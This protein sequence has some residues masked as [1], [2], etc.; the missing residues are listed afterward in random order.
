MLILKKLPQGSI[1]PQLTQAP[2]TTFADFLN[3]FR[4]GHTI[5]D[6]VDAGAVAATMQAAALKISIAS[7]YLTKTRSMAIPDEFLVDI[8]LTASGQEFI[9]TSVDR[10]FCRMAAD[11]APKS[12]AENDGKPHPYVGVVVVKDGNVIATGF[13][14]ETGKGGDHGEFCTLKKVNADVDKVDLS[15]CT[16]YTTLEP[17]TERKEGKT[18]CTDRL[19]NG[20]VERVVYGLAD[21]DESV[22]GHHSIVEAGIK[23]WLF[24]NDLMAELQALNKKWSETRRKSKVLEVPEFLP[25]SNGTSPLANVEYYKPGTSMA[26]NTRFY[27][28]PPKEG[29]GFFTVED[30]TRRVLAGGRTLQE[31]AVKWHQMDDQKVIIEGLR[32]NSSG[33][34]SQLLNLL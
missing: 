8:F 19:I 25:P 29:D 3:F 6:N 10:K 20:K 1:Y 9:Q 28:R 34:S 16:V 21:K 11:L 32:R 18:P 14:G 33:S 31:I 17:C 15:G 23:I 2:I 30:A 24:P 26:D 5:D 22:Y 7:G 12:I 27:V 13:R 4:G